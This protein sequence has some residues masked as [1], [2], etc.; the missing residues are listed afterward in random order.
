MLLR[1]GDTIASTLWPV[2]RNQ[3]WP[4]LNT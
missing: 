1:L 3:A 2:C 4:T